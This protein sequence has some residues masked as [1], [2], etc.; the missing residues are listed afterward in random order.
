MD[1]RLFGMLTGKP[2]HLKTFAYR[3]LHL[4]FCTFQR[5]LTFEAADRVDLVRTQF[6]RTA[7]E[8]LFALL[9][10]CFMPDHV[11]LLIEGRSDDSD[12]LRFIKAAKQYS[13]F[14]YR[15]SFASKLWQRYGFERVLRDDEDT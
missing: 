11:H 8:Q 5:D 14:H 15:Q 2:D 1:C 10:Y 9:A 3:G 12:G 6:R 13:G 4:T 7:A